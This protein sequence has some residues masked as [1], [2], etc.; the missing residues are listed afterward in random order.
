MTAHVQARATPAVAAQPYRVTVIA[1]SDSLDALRS[2]WSEL[3]LDS[4]APSAFLSYEWMTTW[5]RTW[6]GRGTP[7]VVL[8][9]E[10]SQLVGLAP[11]FEPAPGPLAPRTL[12]FMGTG[13]GADHLRFL[14]RRG[15]EDHVASVLT[16]HV[17]AAGYDVLDFPRME[18]GAARI[19]QDSARRGAEYACDA[20]VADTCPFVTL[21]E[22]WEVY[23]GTLSANARKD[24]GRRIRR[25]GERGEVVIRRIHEEGTELQ[26]AWEI[27][28]SL[29]QSRQRTLGSHSAFATPRSLAF[30][31]AFLQTAAARGWL[32]L[33]VMRVGDQDVA[34]EYCVS[35]GGR[36]EDLQTGF[37]A[38]WARYGVGT[39]ILAH[40]IRDAI[41]TGATEFDFLRG[42]EEYKQQRWAAS[43]RHDVSVV[44]WR[45]RPHVAAFVAARR[46]T[47]GLK[48]R[49]RRALAV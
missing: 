17:L 20:T 9:R 25:L 1:D 44:A 40:A 37:D 15:R 39:L 48:G 26:E 42:G 34:A 32:R 8:V 12:R 4:T 7:R 45:R 36:V 49:I 10:G 6:A 14:V 21:P 47:A 35:V 3:L 13:V 2:E 22:S 19:L 29:H 31:R 5:L 27:L 33:Y 16:E 11:L 43:S 46:L 28:V 38:D 30:H 24:L 41:S 18:E 23:L